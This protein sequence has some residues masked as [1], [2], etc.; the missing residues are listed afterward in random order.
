MS[1]LSLKKWKKYSDIE[2]L[3]Y[4]R[5]GAVKVEPMIGILNTSK[6]GEEDG[7][8]IVTRHRATVRTILVAVGESRDEAFKLGYEWLAQYTGALPGQSLPKGTMK[9]EADVDTP[10]ETKA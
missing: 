4:L 9:L 5:K 7:K 10:V 2:R 3:E 1:Q 6:V 8:S